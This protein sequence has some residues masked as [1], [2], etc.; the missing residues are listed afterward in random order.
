MLPQIYNY[1]QDEGGYSIDIEAGADNLEDCA[2]C[3]TPVHMPP[4]N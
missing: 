1:F 2:I 3:L 4:L